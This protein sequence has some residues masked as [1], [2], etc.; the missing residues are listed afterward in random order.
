MRLFLPPLLL[1]A[2]LAA[3]HSKKPDWAEKGRQGRVPA[4]LCSQIEKG[5]AQIA[6]GGGGIDIGDKGDATIPAA[7]WDR[8]SASE[9]DQLLRT[10]AF[11]A[12][13]KSGAQSDALPVVVHD[14]EGNELARRSMSTRVDTS[15]LLRD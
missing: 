14:D 10:I 13:C 6:A 3:C 7:A 15:E 12:A 9:H 8:M 1:L 4:Q 2:A 11:H 5:V